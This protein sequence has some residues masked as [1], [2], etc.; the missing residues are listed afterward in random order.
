MTALSL[1]IVRYQKFPIIDF[2]M[3][4]TCPLKMKKT[5]LLYIAL[6]MLAIGAQL[7]FHTKK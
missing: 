7:H 4:V 3:M 1:H 2:E 6:F 5:C